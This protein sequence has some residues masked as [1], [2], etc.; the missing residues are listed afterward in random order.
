MAEGDE[1][2]TTSQQVP[3]TPQAPHTLSMIKLPILKKKFQSLI[4]Q[5]EIHGAGDS[6]EDVNQKFLRSVPFSWS[7]VSLIMRTKPGVNTLSFDDLYNNLRVFES[8]VKG[9]TTSSSG[10]QNVTFVSFNSPNST[11]EVS[12]AYDHDD[13]EHVDEFDFKEIDLKWQVAMISTRLKK[14]YKKTGRKLHF[15]AKEPVGFDKSKV[16]YFNCHNTGHFAKEFK[17]KG[18]Q[19]NRRRDAGNTC[20]KARENGK[21][22]AK[23]D[24]QKDMIT[25]D[26]EG[27]DWTGHIKDDT[28]DYALMTFNSSNSGSDTEVTSCSKI[29]EETYA[30]LKSL[31]KEQGEQLGDASIEI[32]AYTLALKKIEAQ[33][34]CHQKNQ[35]DYE[36]KIS[37][38]SN[39]EDSPV[40]DRFAKVKGMH[41]VLPPMTENYMPL[42]SNF[43]IDESKFTFDP[44]QSTTS[45]SDTKT[46]DLDYCV[47]SSSV[48]T[49]ETVP[50]PD[51]SKPTVVSEPK[52]WS[53]A[54][55]IEEYESDSDDE[56]TL[57]EKVIIDSGCS[58]HMTGNKAYLVD[59][60][61]YNGGPV[62]FEDS[63]GQIIVN[64]ACYVLNTVL[65]TKPQNK[66][67]YELLTGKIPIISYLRLFGCHA[68]ILNT[69][70][71]LGKFEEKSNEGFLVGYPLS[72]KAFRVYNLESKRVEENL[73]I[74]FLE[75][76]PNVAGKGPT[77]LF[78][79]DYL[80]DSMNYQPITVENKA[81][82]TA[83][84]KEANHSAGT[85]DFLIQEILKWK[86]NMLKNTSTVKSS[87]PLWSSYTSTV[88]SLKPKNGNEN[89]HADANSKI[90]D[91]PVDQE[92][93]AF[94]EELKRLKNQEKEAN[95]ASETL[96]K[97]D[98]IFIN[99]SYDDE[100]A[101]AD[102]TTL[103]NTVNVSPIPQ[104]RIHSIYP[105]TQILGDPNLAV[106]TR[107]KVNKSSGAHGF[108]KAIGTKWVYRNKKDERG[109][110]V[111][112]KARLVSQGHRQEEGI[113]YDQ[114]GYKR[115]L[116]DKT[117]FIKKDKKDIMLVQVYVNDI[118]FGSTKKSWCDEFE[119]LTKS[120]FQ[121]SF[122]GE[123]TFFLG[124]QV[125]QKEDGI[126]ISKDK[127]VVEILKKFDFLSVKTSSTPIE[128][129]KPLVKDEEATDVDVHLYRSMIGS[130]MYLTAFRP[131]IMYAVCACSRFQVT[132][133]TSHLQVVKRIFRYLKG[134][135]KLGLWY[136]RE[137]VLTW[138]PTQIVTMLEKILTG[139]PQ[140]KVVNF[141]FTMSNRHQELASPEQT[142]SGKDFSNPLIADS[143]LKTIWF[144]THHASQVK[145]WLVQSKRLLL[146]VN[147][148]R[149]KLTT[150]RVYAVEV[151][152]LESEVIDIKTTYQER[153]KK[154]K[155]RVEMLEEENRVLKELKNVHSTVDVD[156]PVMKEE[157]SSKQGRKITDI[158]A[159]VDMLNDEEPAEVKEVLE[160]V[161]A[162]K[163]M[164]EVVTTAGATKKALKE[165]G[166]NLE[167]VSAKK[168]KMEEK[169]EELKRH[170]PFVLDD[171][172]DVYTDATPLA[173]KILIIDYK[174]H[175]ERNR[176]YFKII[177]ADGNHMLF[178]SL[179]TML[180]IFDRED[181]ES[182]W[183]II[184]DTFEKTKPKNYSDDYLLNTLKI[185]FEKPNVEASVWKDKKGRYGL[186]KVKSWK[187]IE[188]CG[189]HCITFSAIQI[190]LLVERVTLKAGQKAGLESVKARI[191]V[192]QKNEAVYEEDIA[193]LKLDVQLRDT[194][195]VTLRQ[196]IE[197]AEQEKD[198][199]KLKLEKF[200][201]SFNNLAKLIASQLDAN[202][203]TG[204]G[205]GNHVNGC[206]A[207]DS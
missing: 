93:Q 77:W 45:E 94:L 127:Y 194:A 60:Q 158:N 55:I 32:Q 61:D 11:N 66:T 23:Q 128:T 205:Y 126:F 200:E 137:S 186:A 16:E 123:L 109:V 6:I 62:A 69:I 96:R 156:E 162:A 80:T 2:P 192:H 7:Q 161:K 51:V 87:K 202:N 112:N 153:I 118:I 154:L 53:D 48:E 24:E 37:K 100:G 196:K 173:S 116:I 199:L 122:M 141:L 187:L 104:S 101:E 54:P 39:V 169:T 145:S 103:K 114:S 167:Q 177:R 92:D 168:Q 133:K 47:S 172:D 82:K 42:K 79:L 148:A 84:L 180:K 113:D 85:Q 25:I 5:L 63:K 185:M 15:D 134:Q 140:Q 72:S 12:T 151:I 204:L 159:D 91:E 10:T 31:Y 34:V 97:T 27:V 59:Y 147:A 174:I 138:K 135:P 120:R 171:D 102:F 182:L 191:V 121:M 110:V 56:H 108:K 26:G 144:S 20:Y 201:T 29:C 14:F 44:K 1:N 155:G 119:A 206:E 193:S 142:A 90:N 75:N 163:L 99:A 76:K 58:R 164:T 49:L 28:E 17:S 188:S 183:I 146:K 3:L 139:N 195:L 65:V 160:I 50:K 107:S 38:S 176:P 129:K 57:K 203:K 21:R 166:K 197:K 67:P 106:Q 190:F 207:N 40:N 4:S 152:D 73:H 143:L 71:H 86:L 95:D 64:T 179:S 22:H 33:L 136:P 19:D 131:D 81:N 130:L 83:S 78:D 117:L 8:D 125:K 13:L 46:S 105:T 68:T 157:K 165:K 30:K 9:S 132:P 35:L 181:L 189:V 170:L 88:K 124:L 149:L 175:T 36:E 98:E 74:N 70:N 111:R 115:G 41:A 18:N 89:L 178:I 184:R 52:I 150:A 43:G 198:N